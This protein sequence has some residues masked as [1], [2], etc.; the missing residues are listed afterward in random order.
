MDHQ[1]DRALAASAQLHGKGPGRAGKSK[2]V[3]TLDC[4]HAEDLS[5]QLRV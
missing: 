4:E 2:S 3:E 1:L 5:D